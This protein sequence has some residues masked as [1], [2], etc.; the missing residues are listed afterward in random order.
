[1]LGSQVIGLETRFTYCARR[2]TSFCFQ[3]ATTVAC[4]ARDYLYPQLLLDI[5]SL[6][7]YS[8]NVTIDLGL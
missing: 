2:L 1:V 5:N 4:I 6:G 8:N 3:L 7:H